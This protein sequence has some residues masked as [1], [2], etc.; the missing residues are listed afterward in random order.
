MAC[1]SSLSVAADPGGNGDE[2]IQ[3]LSGWSQELRASDY[4]GRIGGEEFA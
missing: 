2:R 3:R 4:I 1:R